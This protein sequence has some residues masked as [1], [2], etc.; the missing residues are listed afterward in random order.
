MQQ[1]QVSFHWSCWKAFLAIRDIE[2]TFS[3]SMAWEAEEIVIL[4]V[5]I[6]LQNNFWNS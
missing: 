1:V 3:K 4:T 2:S 6:I 5:N